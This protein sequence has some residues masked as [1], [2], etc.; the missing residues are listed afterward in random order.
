MAKHNNWRQI[1]PW[2]FQV[3]YIASEKTFEPAELYLSNPNLKGLIKNK[4]VATSSS[5]SV[6]NDIETNVALYF[7]VAAITHAGMT[8]PGGWSSKFFVEAPL[9][10]KNVTRVAKDVQITNKNLKFEDAYLAG[11]ILKARVKWEPPVKSS[12]NTL[13]I[14]EYAVFWIPSSANLTADCR[15]DKKRW[16]E[17]L[18]ASVKFIDS[19]DAAKAKINGHR[20]SSRID[21]VEVS[22]QT[23]ADAVRANTSSLALSCGQG[24]VSSTSTILTISETDFGVVQAVGETITQI[25]QT[26]TQTTEAKGFLA[27]ALNGATTTIAVDVDTNVQGKLYGTFIDQ[28][29]LTINSTLVTAAPLAVFTPSCAAN[30]CTGE[31]FSAHSGESNRHGVC[32]SA[33]LSA[34]RTRTSSREIVLD[35]MELPPSYDDTGVFVVRAKNDVGY[36]DW[37]CASAKVQDLTPPIPKNVRGSVDKIVGDMLSIKLDWYDPTSKKANKGSEDSKIVFYRVFQVNENGIAVNPR[38]VSESSTECALK[39]TITSECRDEYAKEEFEGK[40]LGGFRGVRRTFTLRDLPRLKQDRSIVVYKFR[41]MAMNLNGD[42]VLSKP[43]YGIKVEQPDAPT[44][45]KGNTKWEKGGDIIKVAWRPPFRDGGEPVISNWVFYS[46]DADFMDKTKYGLHSILSSHKITKDDRTTLNPKGCIGHEPGAKYKLYDQ[47][48]KSSTMSQA[49]K[50]KDVMARLLSTANEEHQRAAGLS[51]TAKNLTWA[52]FCW[53]VEASRGNAEGASESGD[54][55][56]VHVQEMR[57]VPIHLNNPFRERLPFYAAVAAQNRIGLS[58]PSEVSP[59]MREECSAGQFLTTTRANNAVVCA[60]CTEGMDCSKCSTTPKKVNV[61]NNETGGARTTKYDY[62][63]EEAVC[64]F[65]DVGARSMF[66]KLPCWSCEDKIEGDGPLGGSSPVVATSATTSTSTTGN[67]SGGNGTLN[68]SR[69]AAFSAEEQAQQAIDEA[70]QMVGPGFAMC[71]GVGCSTIR[72]RHRD[73]DA[74]GRVVDLS[75]GVLRAALRK[76]VAYVKE[77]IKGRAKKK[78]IYTFLSES[79]LN[80]SFTD[81]APAVPLAIPTCAELINLTLLKRFQ[82]LS[83]ASADMEL[84]PYENTELV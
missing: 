53:Q 81:N 84:L 35:N 15:T 70:R 6:I 10:P 38:K 67:F 71:A 9:R 27:K 19:E 12:Q 24:F 64:K 18:D 48:A 56:K 1:Q 21:G 50:V 14:K 57:V 65:E 52:P 41:I 80:R 83:A 5:S 75:D 69:V 7:S 31:D 40:S 39:D 58:K 36:G 2:S 25:Q 74:H 22:E 77:E 45:E 51:A 32:C 49:N 72:C 60:K 73:A 78:D 16:K 44:L 23:C 66:W 20:D 59:Q 34:I 28:F 47:W 33:A 46:Q 68:G 54:V 13:T 11:R 42:S 29:P 30:P 55:N 3:Y 37:S 26:V 63:E 4:T 17:Q 8:E 61:T 79:S 43:T 62:I 76:H 82:N